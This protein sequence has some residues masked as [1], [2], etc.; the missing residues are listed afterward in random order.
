[1]EKRYE[2]NPKFFAGQPPLGQRSGPGRGYVL[3]GL[4]GPERL[5]DARMGVYPVQWIHGAEP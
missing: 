3:I 1:M 4:Y 5:P 2:E